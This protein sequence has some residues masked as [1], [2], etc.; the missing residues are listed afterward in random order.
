MAKTI[1]PATLTVKNYIKKLCEENGRSVNETDLYNFIDEN[2]L[3]DDE[4]ES[5]YSLI[6]KY[7]IEVTNSEDFNNSEEPEVQE[8]DTAVYDDVN[9]TDLNVV[10]LY[11]QDIKR[12]PLLT[13]EEELDLAK[14]IAQ[15]DKAARELFIN[16]NLRL[17]INTAKSY[18]NRGV[19][20]ADLIQEGNIGL[21]RAVEKYDY[22]SGYRFS[23]YATWWIRQRTVKYLREHSRSI[24][25]PIHISTNS[26]KVKRVIEELC[27]KNGRDPTYEEIAEVMNI[28]EEKIEQLLNITKDIYSIDTPLGSGDKESTMGDYLEDENDSNQPEEAIIQSAL[29]E[30]IN[31][32]LDTLTDREKNIMI[33]RYGLNNTPVKTLEDIGNELGITRERVR[34]IEKKVLRKLR[35]PSKSRYIKDFI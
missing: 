25:I 16:S 26:Q 6:E 29:S 7:R 1:A 22:T 4:I 30:E 13:A 23:T 34:Q 31:K 21:L 11:Y 35:H 3:T 27:E 10:Q 12:Y 8:E 20:I 14:K 32:M 28:P 33:M 18:L 2:H 5:L 24:K 15:G 17:V 19:D 9:I